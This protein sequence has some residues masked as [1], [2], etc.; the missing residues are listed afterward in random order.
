MHWSLEKHYFLSNQIVKP[1][2]K[3]RRQQ[4]HGLYSSAFLVSEKREFTI[5]KTNSQGK[6]WLWCKKHRQ[7][8]PKFSELF[9]S[10]YLTTDKIGAAYTRKHRFILQDKMCIYLIF[11][12][13]VTI[14]IRLAMGV[15]AKLFKYCKS[16]NT[17]FQ[18]FLYVI[19]HHVQ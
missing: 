14:S 8:L 19:R 1:V 5:M 11:I 10:N 4:M 15:V 2:L 6:K 12:I 9:E 16:I 3:S 17:R 13:L 18:N 7:P